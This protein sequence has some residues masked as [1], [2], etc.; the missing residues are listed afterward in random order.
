MLRSGAAGRVVNMI[1]AFAKISRFISVIA[2]FVAISPC[3]T[4]AA[5]P[6]EDAAP[7]SGGVIEGYN[8]LIFAFNRYVFSYFP[9]NVETSNV[10]NAQIIQPNS[11]AISEKSSGFGP[12]IYNLINEPITIAASLLVGDVSM[13]WNSLSRFTINST[14]GVLGWWDQASSMGYKPAVADLGLSLCRLGV[15]EGGYLVLPFIGPRTV[16]DAVV[17]VVL[18]NALLWTASGY[19]FNSGVSFQT[20]AIAETIEIAADIVATRQIDPQAKML[21]YNDFDKMRSDYLTQRRERCKG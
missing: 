12:V 6:T 20:I 11:A 5:T 17:D 8:H 10:D 4:M 13:A 16:R 3:S 21:D 14:Y 15:G 9:E 2:I 19:I 1:N 7:H 18:V